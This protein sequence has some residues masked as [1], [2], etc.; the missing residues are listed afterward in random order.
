M[1]LFL[2][3][4]KP[5][6][7][8]LS[9]KT[10]QI[11]RLTSI[12]LISMAFQVSAS[13]S[14]QNVTFKGSNL[15]PRK[16]LSVLKAQTNYVFFYEREIFKNVHS[17][18]LDLKN[19][20]LETA[21]EAVFANEPISWN[22]VE[23]TVFLTTKKQ[24][25]TANLQ[26]QQSVVKGKVTNEKGE[27]LPGVNI[28]EKGTTNGVQSDIDG[29]F[30]LALKNKNAVLVISYIGFNTQEAVVNKR[31]YIAITLHESTSALADVVVMGYGAR[32]RK[33]VAG[34]I[35]QISGKV[36]ENRP[37]TNVLNALQG[38]L[39]GLT[40]TRSS[41]QPGAEGYA[42][43]VRGLSSLNGG[44]SPLV[45]V[46][47]V[48]TDI[49]TINIYD[50]K[51]VSLLKDASAAIYG[52]RAAGGVLLITTKE[53]KKNQA[54][55]V[56]YSTNY[57]TTVI[58][59]LLNRVSTKK[60]VEMD[61]EAQLNVGGRSEF[62]A[63]GTVA[64]VF[65]K[66]DAG[67]APQSI[68]SNTYLF[69]KDEDW[70]KALFDNGVQ[71]NHNIAISGGGD[72]SDYATSFGYTKTDG[73]LRDA[74]DSNEQYNL[75][76]NYGV[77]IT[78]RLRLGSKVFYDRSR[79]LS[80]A[81]GSREIFSSFNK[82]FTWFPIYTQSGEHYSSQWGFTN[83]KQYSD[84]AIGKSTSLT[85]TLN[86]NF[87]LN[88]K[89]TEDLKFSGQASIRRTFNQGTDFKSPFRD[90]SY[91]DVGARVRLDKASL[92]EGYTTTTYKNFTSYLDYHKQF[93][94]HDISLT[95]GASQEEFDNKSFWASRSGFS[96]EA[97]QSLNLGN[98][99]VKDNS[100]NA[101][102]WAIKSFFG[103]ATYIFN[104][105]YIAEFNFRRDGTSV[106]SPEKRWGNFT[107]VSLSWLASEEKFIKNLNIFDQLK[108]RA[109]QGTTGNQNLNSGNLYDYISLINIGGAY[110]FGNGLKD[111]SA[112]EKSLVSR[113][114]TWETLKTTNF[115][116]DFAVLNSRLSG[117]F[118][119]YKK[120]NRNMLLGVNLPSVLGGT[121]PAKNIGSLDTK[122]FELSLKWED[123]VSDNF[124][125]SINGYLS[126]NTNILVD[127]DGRD[128]VGSIR[129]G[130]AFGT[131][132]GYVYDGIIRSQ[133][134]L[135]A[136][137]ILGGVPSN[138]SLGDVKFKDVNG[139]GRI[140]VYDDNQK[141]ADVVD[142]GT[143]SARYNFG[144]NLSAKYKNFDVSTFVQG[145]GKRTLF[146][147]GDFAYPFSQPWWQ[148]LERFY[149]NTWS[150]A[151]PTAKYPKMYSGGGN[152]TWNYKTSELTKVSGAY[153]RLKNITIGYS[154]PTD[155]L[156][157]A[158]ISNLRIYVSGEDLFTID[159]VDGG[160]DPE[161]TDGSDIFYPFTK[162]FSLGLTLT[163]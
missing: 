125:Y 11:M 14:S 151:N 40:V 50:I 149:N 13:V 117:S 129:E 98:T 34:A 113:T 45:L 28:L 39:P 111:Q 69:F 68:G 122:G 55:S 18:N 101:F 10:K 131:I 114:R 95:A 73:I 67:A 32:S 52:A 20:T 53:G 106:F 124:S 4:N 150:P 3:S 94:K 66:I 120:E 22:I 138:I 75:R 43:N 84:K 156:K 133:T 139:D 118:D 110:P 90:W 1:K 96:Q 92:A 153:A 29:N 42:L 159:S 71:V 128:Q 82:N 63:A 33:T 27:S 102:Q 37:V 140:S 158:G 8:W 89:I 155:A 144:F 61:T 17:I 49:A 85:E 56:T 152:N 93:A 2:H 86:G 31:N 126:D 88:Y 24:N 58:S 148:P 48:E 64:E 154:L 59:N 35:E 23:K 142:L 103:R 163:F 6:Q 137:K 141:D 46:D 100:G 38:V 36:L 57:A 147:G 132:F 47:G 16:V 145:V 116:L 79:M 60:W 30:N 143:N 160:Y 12:L 19:A 109:S 80:P 62:A 76:L 130:Y 91:N 77:D 99:D 134:D 119:V 105:K 107:G 157:K 5:P 104:S 9:A 162:R 127:L 65:A 74:W 51:T 123:R 78:D 136:Y 112:T 26:I 25:F 135:D 108:V 15:S 70:N 121:P 21:L 161:N 146:Y 54:T 41:G 83:P 97:V 7:A 87:T 81:Y 115:G 44:N 72:H